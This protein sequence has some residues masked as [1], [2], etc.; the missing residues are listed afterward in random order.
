M[1]WV[2]KN[3]PYDGVMFALHLAI[4][5][6]VNDVNDNDLW[7]SAVYL[8][9]KARISERSTRSGLARMVGDGLLV[10]L[11]ERP[12]HTTRY[13]FL[14]PADPCMDC[15]PATSAPLH[16]HAP[17]PAIQRETPATRRAT[18]AVAAPKL[19]NST[20]LKGNPT[21]LASFDEFWSAYPR[22]VAKGA[23][24]TAWLKAVKIVDPST[25]IAGAIS[26]ANDPARKPEYTKHPATWLNAEC[27]EDEADQERRRSK[28]TTAALRLMQRHDS[29]KELG[30]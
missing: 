22:K 26:Y 30:A 10:K 4:A 21:A 23:A 5:D 27:W 24:R 3:S 19:N 17:T 20:E 14:M 28:G 9:A 2:F 29:P 25:L 18:P 8:S 11:E 6:V 1:G 16:P 15:T 13:R 7:A 12:G